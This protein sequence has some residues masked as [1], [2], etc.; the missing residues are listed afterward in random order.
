MIMTPIVRLVCQALP[1]AKRKTTATDLHYCDLEKLSTDLLQCIRQWLY[2]A[3]LVFS[4]VTGV[5]LLHAWHAD[6]GS[7]VYLLTQ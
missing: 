4:H 3:G 5:E 7:E 6:G 1:K 2:M